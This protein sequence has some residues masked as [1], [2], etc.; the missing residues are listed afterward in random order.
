M[1]KSYDKLSCMVGVKDI[2][3]AQL[4]IAKY[5]NATPLIYSNYFSTQLSRKVYFKCES[6]QRTGSFKI[7]GA[8]HRLLQL[9]PQERKTGIVT[10]SYGNLAQAVASAGKTVNVKTTVVMPI[11]SSMLKIEYAKA[12]GTEVI[13][14]G[15]TFEETLKK[16]RAVAKQQDAIFLH[17]FEDDAMIAGAGTVGLEILEQNPDTEAVLV[18]VGGGGLLAGIAT[19]IKE[20]NSKIAVMGVQTQHCS[21]FYKAYHSKNI[22]AHT[23]ETTPTIADAINIGHVSKHNYELV[24]PLIDDFV[25][26]SDERLVSTMISILEQG[27]LVA[28]GAAAISLSALLE[29]QVPAKYR[30]VTLL[31]SG[32]NVDSALLAKIINHGLSK[33]QRIVR[34][35]VVVEDQPGALNKI[36]EVLNEKHINIIQIFHNR[37]I[38][39]S[40]FNQT[41]IQ[42]VLEC[43]GETHRKEIL[44]TIQKTGI[45]KV[46]D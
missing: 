17:P 4:G 3:K 21:A 30:N 23:E 27:H 1:V 40:E 15:T 43:Q 18:P 44:D 19:A 8:I 46:L 14:H 33:R 16:A 6:F 26:V 24:E 36:T 35:D 2:S 10:A 20:K 9:T 22:E 13:L 41:R 38:S 25:V 11:N 7:R 31:I 28:E 29:E 39:E 37:I 5:L 42:L 32:G 45:V 34:V 12:H